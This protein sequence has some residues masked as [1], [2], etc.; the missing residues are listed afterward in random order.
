M[1]QLSLPAITTAAATASFTTAVAEAARS[2]LLRPR[3]VHRQVTAVEI[4]AVE[5]LDGFLGLLG[6]SHLDET[7]TARATREL[8]G[9]HASRFN[10]SVHR[11]DFL[12]LRISGRIWQ[13]TNIDFTAHVLS[14]LRNV[15]V[16]A[17]ENLIT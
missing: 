12:E 2:S 14:L 3:F 1:V 11:K 6:G 17:P 4:R 5:S 9:D 7:K 15:M 10:G 8:I 16:F 13:T